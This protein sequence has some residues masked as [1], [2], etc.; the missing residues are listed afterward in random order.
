MPDEVER[1]VPRHLRSDRDPDLLDQALEWRAAFGGW[2]ATW[3]EFVHGIG[4]L[5]RAAVREQARTADAVA[6]HKQKQAD[7]RQW[8]RDR[9]T[10]GQ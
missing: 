8:Q 4:H 3:P 2:P 7:Y 9:E 5:G 10:L 6:A 1:P